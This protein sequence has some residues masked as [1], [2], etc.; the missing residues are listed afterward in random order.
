MRGDS[1]E[2]IAIIPV[3]KGGNVAY[4]GLVIWENMFAINRDYIRFLNLRKRG[5]FTTF[6][7]HALIQH[8]VATEALPRFLPGWEAPP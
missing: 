5:N 4:V 7:V 2:D 6:M 1:F 8:G 3:Y